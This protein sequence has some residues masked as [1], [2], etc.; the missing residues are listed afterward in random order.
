M[1]YAPIIVTVYDRLD[2][3]KR[4]ITAL[5]ANILAKESVLYIL[6]DAAY[7][8]EHEE[9]IRQI[10]DYALSINGFKEVI[11]FF[12]ESNLG[13][14][15]SAQEGINEILKTNKSFIFL[16]DDIVVSPNFLQYMNDGL[17]YYEQQGDIFS[18]CAYR[19]S[20]ALPKGYNKDIYF[21]PCNS[22][23]GYATWKDRWDA[24]NFDAFD[25]YTELKKNKKEYK[26][27]TSIGF[28]VKGILQADSRGKIQAGDLRIYYHMFQNNMCSVFPVVSKSQNWGLDGTGEHGGKNNP[29][30][31]KPTLDTSDT[32]TRFEPFE[33]YDKKL[34]NNHRKFQDKIN[35]GFLAKH[36][37][38]TWVHELWKKFKSK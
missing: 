15:R 6:S 29:A 27:F 20:F 18:I 31:A 3:F 28:Y 13:A 35:G 8:R 23:W 32:P 21:Y 19:A 2:H 17:N 10:R 5:Q 24:V 1:G 30:W 7:K 36:L 22:P 38:Y 33:G 34:L 25:R 12:R 14:H 37:K 11:Y 26:K 16:E 9:V 4:C